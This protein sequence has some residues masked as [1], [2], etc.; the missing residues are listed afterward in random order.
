MIVLSILGGI[1]LVFLAF[2]FLSVILGV[3]ISVGVLVLV[4]LIFA[5]I[6]TILG[7]LLILILVIA[8]GIW[9]LKT[10]F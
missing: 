3:L 1:F 9:F 5:G 4:G 10:I 2:K 8:G 6:L 7:P